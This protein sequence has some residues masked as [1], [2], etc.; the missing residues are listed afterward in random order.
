M[1]DKLFLLLFFFFYKAV[2]A[3]GLSLDKSLQKQAELWADSVYPTLSLE[4]RVAQIILLNTDKES[5]L[6]TAAKLSPSPGF[7]IAEPWVINSRL[8]NRSRALDPV[9]IADIR[10]GYE[11]P[12]M[13]LPFPDE[14]TMALSLDSARE[15]L[16][17]WLSRRAASKGVFGFMTSQTF[18][19]LWLDGLINKPAEYEAFNLWIPKSNPD[20]SNSAVFVNVALM[21]RQIN[22]LLLSRRSLSSISAAGAARKSLN[23]T[24]DKSFVPQTELSVEQLLLD[25]TLLLSNDFKNDYERLISAFRF[26]WLDDDLLELAC[27]K[28]LAFKYCLT[29]SEHYRATDTETENCLWPFHLAYESSVSLFQSRDKQ[30]FPLVNLDLNIAY[31]NMGALHINSFTRMADNYIKA[32]SEALLPHEYDV[33][34]LM[35]DPSYARVFDLDKN[36]KALKDYYPNASLVMIWGG[37]PAMLPFKYLPAGL[38]ALFASPSNI[39]LAWE[40]MAQVVFNG[41]ASSKRNIELVYGDLSAFS[42][43]TGVSR[44]KYGRATEVGMDGDTLK[45]IDEIVENA[46][47]QGASPGAQLLVARKG[48]VI[49]NKSYG[50]HSY[51]KKRYVKNS[52]IY[53][54]ASVTKIA[55][56]MPVAMKCYDDGLWYLRDAIKKYLPQADSSDKGDITIRQLLLHRSGLQA[57][58]PF[59]TEIIDREKLSGTLYSRRR[60]SSHPIRV[61]EHLYMNKSAVFK[62]YLISNYHDMKFSVKVADNLYL[63]HTYID[64][65]HT[66]ILN[67]KLRKGDYLYSDLNFILLTRILERTSGQPL[68]IMADKLFYK[69]LGSTTLQFNPWQ[70]GT[71]ENV[72]PSENDRSFRKQLLKGYVHDQTAALLGGV[73]G[74]AGLFGNANDLAKLMQMY[75]NRG[76]YGGYRF[77]HDE[78]IDFF[79]SQ[80]EDDSRRGLGFDKPEN[81]PDKDSPVSR[82]ASPKSYG[83]SGFTGT[84]VWVDPTYDLIYIFLSNRVHPDSFNRK[85]SLLNVRTKIQDVIYRSI[86][87]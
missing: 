49:M 8:P 10:S 20:N 24:Q 86:I 32:P 25:G 43:N 84:I 68:D 76:E 17:D 34:F 6:R 11:T 47:R 87:D 1:K 46:I 72:V 71:L 9:V 21:P 18:K 23:L 69:R 35:S 63:N 57:Y 55:A 28:A 37:S 61:D 14:L 36:I 79:T 16:I 42:F 50:W 3:G 82:L 13:E 22:R 83:H 40:A 62:D 29:N 52:D 26:R 60:S 48:V 65:I 66:Q 75:L 58:I 4:A 70:K 77:I 81:N 5:E 39:P 7:L 33:I 38:D 31:Y 27:K 67:S 41:I 54:L 74:H 78:T 44:L 53:D 59:H 12:E 19:Q 85:L 2:L 80:Q 51:E 56:T 45:L 30:L 15:A 64:S 73:A